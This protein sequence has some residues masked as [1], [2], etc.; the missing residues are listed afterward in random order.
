VSERAR[1]ALYLIAPLEE[2][3]DESLCGLCSQ[4][5][6]ESGKNDDDTKSLVQG[7]C[8]QGYHQ[9]GLPCLDGPDDRTG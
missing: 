6:P 7:S 2:I 5:I 1:R 4:V 3:A 9:A 8:S